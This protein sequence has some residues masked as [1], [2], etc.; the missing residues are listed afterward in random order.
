MPSEI[1]LNCL[2]HVALRVKD[3]ATSA[4]WYEKV[5]DLERH[6]V[7]LTTLVES[8]EMFYP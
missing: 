6:T 7:E 8:E 4:S 2:D 5:L 1:T 3:L